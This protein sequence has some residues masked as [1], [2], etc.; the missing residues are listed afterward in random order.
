[1][2]KA[3][4]DFMSNRKKTEKQR[5]PEIQRLLARIS[6]LERIETEQ[7][8]TAEA[9]KESERRYQELYRMVRLM[10]DNVPDLIWAKNLDKHFMFVN[11]A[12][13][14]KLL[15]AADKE[16]PIGKTDMFFAER[17]R[18]LHPGD[19]NWHTFGEIC[20]DSDSIVMKSRQADR[21]DE[22]GNIKGSFLRLDVYKAPFW[23]ENGTMIGTVG[24]GRDVTR[25]REIED[26]LRR[27]EKRYRAIV[28]TQTELI[29]RFLPDGT[30]TFVNEAYCR[31]FGRQ[32]QD[33]VGQNFL[34]LI[35]EEEHDFVHKKFK[36]LTP[37]NQTTTYEHRA[38]TAEGGSRWMRWV[39]QAIFNDQRKLVEFQ[40]VGWDITERKEIEEELRIAEINLQEQV[41]DRTAELS[42]K[43]EQ[44][45]KEI[46]IRRNAEQELQN[47]FTRLQQAHEE[48]K[49]AQLQIIRAAKM[50]SVGMLAA[51]VAHE[52]KNP[53]ATILMGID[54]LTTAVSWDERT[55]SVLESMEDAVTRA[56]SIIRGLLDYSVVS[57]IVSE[58]CSI[59]DIIAKSINLVKHELDKKNIRLVKDLS[60]DGHLIRLDAEKICQVFVNLMLNAIHATPDEGTIT[61]TT[62]VQMITERDTSKS[63]VAGGKFEIGDRVII[64]EIADT[65][66][67]IPDDQLVKVFDPF[68]TV[69]PSGKGTGLGLTVTKNIIESHGGIID[70]TNRK[71]GG[72]SS[73]IVLKM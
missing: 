31:Y 15:N 62:H 53:L 60:R 37:D 65:G 50:E 43:N 42:L 20:R 32:P 41:K 7:K 70:I 10:C 61:V 17:E 71:E 54:Y 69:N 39:D 29:C 8:L 26:E 21:F 28:E 52:V 35:P 34:D 25:E 56:D 73:I 19:T 33:L 9:L 48:L 49:T 44:L 59:H 67:G 6:E 55:G 24:C 66:H 3:E 16:E 11:S 2:R 23:D 5:Q 58:E 30:L 68:F 46:A 45:L 63:Y 1:M 51:G 14:E 64:V 40:S 18:K 27:S 72:V 36:T 4:K 22:F 38:I 57:D 47:A 13:C 12:I